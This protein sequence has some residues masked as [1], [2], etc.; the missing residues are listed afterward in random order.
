[1]MH[2]LAYIALHM[3]DNQTRYL[4]DLDT[5]GSDEI[6][7]QTDVLAKESLLPA[8]GWSAAEMNTSAAVIALAQQLSISPSSSPAECGMKRV[9]IVCLATNSGTR[10]RPLW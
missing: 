9:S 5:E 8:R 6:E 4:D 7:Q 10:L 3:D 1:M 2:E